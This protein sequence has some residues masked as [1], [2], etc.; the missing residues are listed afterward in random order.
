MPLF[1]CSEFHLSNMF[2]M[3]MATRFV[4]EDDEM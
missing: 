1:L 2:G 4:N 3:F